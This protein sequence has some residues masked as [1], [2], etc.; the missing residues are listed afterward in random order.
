VFKLSKR[1]EAIVQQ[2]N[3]LISWADVVHKWKQ[4]ATYFMML[5]ARTL[6]FQAMN[7]LVQALVTLKQHAHVAVLGRELGVFGA[8]AMQGTQDNIREL[9]YS[10]NKDRECVS[11]MVDAAIKVERAAV[12][13]WKKGLLKLWFRIGCS[14]LLL[15]RWDDAQASLEKAAE[16]DP[17]DVLVAK[18][19]KIA[20]DNVKR[21]DQ[22]QAKRFGNAMRAAAQRG[23]GAEDSGDD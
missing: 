7:N 2:R 3:Q 15:K 12:D 11:G 22:K 1:A 17:S 8:S 13:T 9:N 18:K 21:I 4:Q 5:Q 23:A 19:L 16:F 14:Q 6:R 10:R 20:S